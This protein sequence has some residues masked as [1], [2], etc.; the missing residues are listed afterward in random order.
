MPSGSVPPRR[1]SGAGLPEAP[2]SEFPRP[3]AQTARKLIPGLDLRGA[4][5]AGRRA[6]GD[7]LACGLAARPTCGS[8]TDRCPASAPHRLSPFSSAQTLNSKL[9]NSKRAARL[10]RTA[11]SG[12]F[13]VVLMPTMRDHSTQR[14]YQL[15]Q[16]VPPPPLQSRKSFNCKQ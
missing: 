1:D 5:L 12:P 13:R 4:P 16:P 7:L 2:R 8:N 9:K 10:R 6:D 11:H 3:A 14:Y 15:T